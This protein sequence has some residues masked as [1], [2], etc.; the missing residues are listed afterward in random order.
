MSTADFLSVPVELLHRICDHLDFQTIFCSFRCVCKQFQAAIVTYNKFELDF[1]SISK[2]NLELVSYIIRPENIFSLTISNSYKGKLRKFFTVYSVNHFTRLRSL[3][4]DQIDYGDLDRFLQH[5]NIS[6]LVSLSV[7]SRESN[8]TKAVAT[9]SSVINQC[10]LKKLC[11]I[12]FDQVV[13]DISWPVQYTLQHLTIGVCTLADF[14]FILRH[15]SYLLTFVLKE[16]NT[17]SLNGTNDIPFADTSYPELTSLIIE[18]CPYYVEHLKFILSLTPSLVH[19]KLSSNSWSSYS[20]LDGSFWAEFIQTK[21]PLL[22]KFDFVF[23]GSLYPWGGTDRARASILSFQ[24][25]F[26]LDEKHWFVTC[27]YYIT[28]TTQHRIV[29]Y[30]LPSYTR[31]EPGI[32]IRYKALSIDDVHLLNQQLINGMVT[33][34]DVSIKYVPTS[35]ILILR[36]SD[37]LKLS[38]ILNSYTF[39]LEVHFLTQVL[40]TL[41][42]DGKH[43][44]DQI[45]Q[46]MGI[47]LRTNIVIDTSAMFFSHLF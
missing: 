27:D 11:L 41:N 19:L 16:C 26:W 46:Y 31:K 25:P 38:F 45:I 34:E 6:T 8:K 47:G 4:L 44:T 33:T 13:K 17:H 20:L 37:K 29:M 14:H 7:K 5:I 35:L 21:L 2:S 42:L 24:T 23:S 28:S 1:T 15:L 32:I 10:H 39:Q 22:D 18:N 3:T 12:N 43:I 40:T 36:Y 30:T 9:I